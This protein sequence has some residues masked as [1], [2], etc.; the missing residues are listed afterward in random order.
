[1]P[2]LILVV[3]DVPANITLL[4]AKLASEHHDVITATDG[5]EAVSKAR[6]HKPDVILLDCAYAGNGW[7]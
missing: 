6:L 1:M 4:E 2:A 7:F 3:D 5:F